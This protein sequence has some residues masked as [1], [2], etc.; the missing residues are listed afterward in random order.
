MSSLVDAEAA[1]RLQ[2]HSR[3]LDTVR[4]LR[5]DGQPAQ[6]VPQLTDILLGPILVAPGMGW[7]RENANYGW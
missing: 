5:R 4:L 6:T 3:A 1:A 2:V 7:Q